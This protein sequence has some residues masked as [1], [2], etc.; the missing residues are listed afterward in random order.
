[1]DVKKKHFISRHYLEKEVSTQVS[2]KKTSQIF[3]IKGCN[4]IGK[5]TWIDLLENWENIEV[6]GKYYI[7]KYDDIMPSVYRKSEE[8]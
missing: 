4:G 5:T 2:D 1:M 7:N 6:I 8:V 3:V